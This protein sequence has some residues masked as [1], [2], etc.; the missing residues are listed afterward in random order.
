MVLGYHVIFG[1]YGFWLP[2]DPRGSWS[3]FVGAWDLFRFGPATKVE[4][5]A[6]L[7]RMPHDQTARRAARAALKYPPVHLNGVQARAVGRGFAESARKGRVTVL[8]CAILPEHVH[9]VVGRHRCKVEWIVNQMKGAATRQLLQEQLHPFIAW[10]RLDGRAPMCWA[11]KLWKVYLD[12]E[13][14]IARAVAYVEAN[15]IKEGKPRQQWSFVTPFQ[16][17]GIV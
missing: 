7:A 13:E 17:T 3:D 5:R 10:Q 4:T 12:S 2:N 16:P 1:V 11:A 8:A 14:D 15:P 6:S 9:L